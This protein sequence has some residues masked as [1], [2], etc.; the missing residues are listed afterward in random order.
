[1]TGPAPTAV[2]GQVRPLAELRVAHLQDDLAE[3]LLVPEEDP[4]FRQGVISSVQAGVP[5]TYT[6]LHAGVLIPGLQS[7]SGLGLLPGDVVFLS[8]NRGDWSIVGARPPALRTWTPQ[9]TGTTTNPN[10][11]NGTAT[12]TYRMLGP[13]TMWLQLRIAMGTTGT[14]AGSGF[15]GVGDLPL[16]AAEES[17]VTMMLMANNVRYAAAGVV[18]VAGLTISR[19]AAQGTGGLGVTYAAPPSFQVLNGTGVIEVAFP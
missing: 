12:G 16:P 6:V 11:G 3:A 18:N 2:P 13:T 9:L 19:I 10:I 14:V 17:I 7:V 4:P 8:R 15:V 5:P 1:M